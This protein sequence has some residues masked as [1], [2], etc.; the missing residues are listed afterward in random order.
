MTRKGGSRRTENLTS[1]V[2]HRLP[3]RPAGTIRDPGDWAS[4]S[5]SR[6][7]ACVPI[8]PDQVRGRLWVPCPSLPRGSARDDEK[9]GS[10]RTDDLTSNVSHR[11]PGRPAGTIRDL[12]DWA[13]GSGS[14][15]AAYV[16]VSWV[17]RFAPRP[18]MTRKGGSR[19]TDNLTS[20]VSHRLP[21][22]PAG[23][24]RDLGDWA[25]GSGS[26]TAA[27]VPVS[28]DQVR[29]R[30]WVPCPS[31]PRGSARDDEK[32]RRDGGRGFG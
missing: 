6:T 11:L 5:G 28:P 19:R 9:G 24:I 25:S 12:G 26:R 17:L 23:T 30:L 29:G 2:S 10:R 15:T 31:L 14:R 8:S 16:P 27:C 7:A 3:G 4:G 1:N 21:G 32:G 13:S 18:G 22:R 20:N